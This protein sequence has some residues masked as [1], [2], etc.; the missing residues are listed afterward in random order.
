MDPFSDI[1]SDEELI[2]A[3]QRVGLW[4]LIRE[5]SGLDGDIEAL[6]LSAGQKQLLCFARAMVRR[7]KCDVLVLD[8]ATSR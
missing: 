2:G 6:A 8:E 5:Q 4:D 7:K 1:A 3:L